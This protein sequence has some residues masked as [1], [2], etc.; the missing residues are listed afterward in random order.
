LKEKGLFVID[1][2]LVA[3]VEQLIVNFAHLIDEKGELVDFD[4]RKCKAQQAADEANYDMHKMTCRE[5]RFD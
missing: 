5:N 4:E 3:Q 2:D 1:A